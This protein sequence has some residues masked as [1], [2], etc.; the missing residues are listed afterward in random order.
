[1][2]DLLG[3]GSEEMFYGLHLTSTSDAFA[4]GDENI[5]VNTALNQYVLPAMIG[6]N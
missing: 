4:V 2:Q 6:L 5:L 1:M 3:H